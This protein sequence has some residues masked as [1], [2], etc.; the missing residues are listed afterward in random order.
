MKANRTKELAFSAI[1]SAL[2][3]VLLYIG[4]LFEVLD[5][6]AAAM[7][8]LCVLWVMAELGTKWAL[9]VYAATSVLALV[10]LP[11]KLPAVL[12]VLLFGYYP[13]LKA[14]Y[15][16]KLRGI[17]VFGAKLL[18]LNLA[19][20]LMIC[21]MRAFAAETLWFEILLAVSLNVVFLVY[22]IALTRLLRAYLLVWRKRLRIRFK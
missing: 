4:A 17:F 6:S 7:A 8:S 12:F 9:A 1:V 11:V 18:T 19:V 16:R 20:F 2:A 10:L 21:V 15:E 13:P 22:D 5:L 3:V 14:F